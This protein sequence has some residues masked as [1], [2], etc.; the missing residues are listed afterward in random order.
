MNK[1]VVVSN[2]ELHS[3]LLL[4]DSCCSLTNA[5]DHMVGSN[6]YESHAAHVDTPYHVVI[7]HC[8]EWYIHGV[9]RVIIQFLCMVV[10]IMLDVDVAG[11]G[12]SQHTCLHIPGPGSPTYYSVTR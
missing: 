11:S 5:E 10:P 4:V 12:G 8:Q 7:H 3:V 6:A 2:V 1:I 9:C